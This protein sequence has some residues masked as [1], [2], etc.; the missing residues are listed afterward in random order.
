MPLLTTI[1]TTTNNNG[2]AGRGAATAAATKQSQSKQSGLGPGW[3][4]DQ[5]LSFIFKII[6]PAKFKL[7]DSN[8]SNFLKRMFVSNRESKLILFS[9]DSRF[10]VLNS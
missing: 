8:S 2:Q 6:L 4:A 5:F 7:G 9:P 1:T 3:A 10:A